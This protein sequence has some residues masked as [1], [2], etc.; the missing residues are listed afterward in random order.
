MDAYNANP[1]SMQVSIESFVSAFSAPRYLILGDM[2]ELG[3]QSLS[4]H[5]LILEQTKKHHFEAVFL[6]GPVFKEAAQNFHFISFQ[7]S[8]ELC[9]YLVSNP[10]KEGAVLIKGSRGIQ[11]E[12]VLDF[13]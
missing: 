12:K 5:K 9:S 3:E 11:L 6:V 7:N 4:E 2:L 8:D 10:L 1:T 13:L